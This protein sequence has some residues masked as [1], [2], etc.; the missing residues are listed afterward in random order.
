MADI[1][2]SNGGSIG[3]RCYMQL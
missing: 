1:P 2:D 3:Y